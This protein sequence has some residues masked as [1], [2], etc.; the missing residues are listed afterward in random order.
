LGEALQERFRA[1]ATY[2]FAKS[3]HLLRVEVRP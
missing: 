2:T 1:R 3:E